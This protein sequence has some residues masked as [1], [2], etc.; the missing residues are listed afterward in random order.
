MNEGLQIGHAMAEAAAGSAGETWKRVAYEAFVEHAKRHEFFLTED[1]RK[2]NPDL[3]YPP[4][5]RAWGYVATLAR[6]EGVVSRHLFT[7]A[8]SKSVHGMVVTMWRSNIF[9]KDDRN[10]R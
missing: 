6:R 1:V 3:P 5:M 2:D 9:K 10:D 8:K 7:R 4:D